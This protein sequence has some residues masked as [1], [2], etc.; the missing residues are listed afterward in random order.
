MCT[1]TQSYSLKA[2]NE[3]SPDHT[4]FLS[5]SLL[6]ISSLTNIMEISVNN[7]S[8]KNWLRRVMHTEKNTKAPGN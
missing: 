4:L 2:M 8:I 3:M 7:P 1:H 5:L 6:S